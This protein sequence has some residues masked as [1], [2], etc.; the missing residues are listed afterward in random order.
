MFIKNTYFAILSEIYKMFTFLPREFANLSR[1][2]DIREGENPGKVLQGVTGA[3]KN[4]C[5]TRK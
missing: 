1:R 3:A 2:G 5:K 4:Q